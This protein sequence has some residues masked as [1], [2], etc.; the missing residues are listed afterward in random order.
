MLKV[1]WV[2]KLYRSK[3]VNL[4]Y[5]DQWWFLPN[6]PH[7]FCFPSSPVP[8]FFFVSLPFLNSARLTHN[9]AYVYNRKMCYIYVY[10]FIYIYTRVNK[11]ELSYRE[12]TITLGKVHAVKRH[13]FAALVTFPF[14][15]A[16]QLPSTTV[17]AVNS[18]AEVLQPYCMCCVLKCTNSSAESSYVNEWLVDQTVTRRNIVIY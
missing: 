12:V 3:S 17:I 10:I 6:A 5:S 2:L 18:V 11:S 14:A 16:G 7:V 1:K 15:H 13:I 4:A 8:F 9:C